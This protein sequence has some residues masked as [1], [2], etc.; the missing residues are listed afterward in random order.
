[1][2][3]SP[4]L[5]CIFLARRLL[6]TLENALNPLL[7][8]SG[9]IST[10]NE[11]TIKEATD[12]LLTVKRW[13][14]DVLY[15]LNPSRDELQG[16][17]LTNLCK[18]FTLGRLRKDGRNI[19]DCLQ[20]IPSASSWKQRHPRLT[21]VHPSGF[22]TYTLHD[23]LRF[24]DGSGDL[25]QGISFFRY[26]HQIS[27]ATIGDSNYD[28]DLVRERLPIDLAVLC[29]IVERLFG[30][31][32]MTV[33]DRNRGSLHGVL[34][35]RTWIL[36]LWKDFVTFK[37][38]ALAPLQDLAQS[39]ES[40]MKDVFTGEYLRHTINDFEFVGEFG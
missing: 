34:L 23:F 27:K 5:N 38:G 39:T 26:I 20:H 33:T 1:V 6:G 13:A 2:T 28:R 3:I 21:V 29:S 36:A 9:S 8:L 35:P 24:I 4:G 12:G 10:L 16:A 11:D 18:A 19:D 37:D 14:F 31:A 25:A 40:L 32:V 22:Q 15:T 7:Y 30:L 17:F